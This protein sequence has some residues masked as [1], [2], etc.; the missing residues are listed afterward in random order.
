MKYCQWCDNAFETKVSYQIY[1]SPECRSDATKQKIIERYQANKRNNRKPRKCKS[2]GITLS[3]YND[4]PTCQ[5]CSVNPSDV[6]KALKDLKGIAN[7]KN[8]TDD[9]TE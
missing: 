6:L 8:W 5:N 2:C 1:C 3:I 7:G 9:K 4:E